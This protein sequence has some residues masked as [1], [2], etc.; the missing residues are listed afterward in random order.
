MTTRESDTAATSAPPSA[1]SIAISQQ[2]LHMMQHLSQVHA[3]LGYLPGEVKRECATRLGV[4]TEHL[5]RI[6]RHYR[7]TGQV[8]VRP[9]STKKQTLTNEF[10]AQVAFFQ[11]RGVVRKAWEIAKTN[12]AIPDSMGYKTFE[13]RV[14]EWDPAL[15]ACAKGGYRAMVKEQFFNIEHI[16]F[17]GYAYGSDHTALPIQV[18]PE[19]G[20]KPVWPWLTTLVDLATRA[21]LAYKVTLHTPNSQDNIDVFLEAVKG[22]ETEDGVFVGGKPN[23][24][25][26]D[27]GGDY[28]SDLLAHNLFNL[29]VG[30]QFTEPYSS[31]QN[32]RVEALN[33]TIDEDFAPTM[34][35]FHSG[36]EVAYTR[37]VLKTPLDPASLTTIEDL[38]RRFGDWAGDYN[39][40]VHSGLNGLTPLE[41]WAADA[42]EVERA[43]ADT[44]RNAM[45]HRT[46]AKL[47]H[48]G[49]DARKT[50]YSHPTL[51]VLR[52]H[53]VRDIELRW[54]E[55]NRNEVEVFVEGVH[56]VTALRTSV[57]P[58]H[59]RLG[60]L[61]IRGKQQRETQRLMRHADHAR[62]MADRE[63]M[64]E[65]GH[66][67]EDLPQ[68]PA[69][70]DQ[71]D[72]QRN[73]Q[74]DEQTMALFQRALSTAGDDV[75]GTASEVAP[76]P[77]KRPGI[78]SLAGPAPDDSDTPP[79]ETDGQRDDLLA[80]F[81]GLTSNPPSGGAA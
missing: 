71:V 66:A 47:Q 36:G 16:P 15:R 48:Y 24:L 61:S 54:H 74:V 67:I 78:P 34:P 39:N 6:V 37:R 60:V 55:H 65:E 76:A 26:T 79:T 81:P 75:S 13:R 32:G 69:L 62:V 53:G 33:G 19:R 20:T 21:L 27:R 3:D 31:W 45:T 1:A 38:D 72:G 50:I 30:R 11:A 12:G 49:I 7:A 64:L 56:Q 9:G 41:A 28:I 52:Q 42:H 18:I 43:D 46:Q 25:R 14:K 51:S 58:E 57:Q 8:A 63:R 59:H 73:G 40:K 44:I 35:G 4:H 17:K 77:D 5:S 29:D 22:W 68:L 23:F 2:R 80:Q 70:P 10:A